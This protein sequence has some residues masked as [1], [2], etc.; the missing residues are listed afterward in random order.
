MITPAYKLRIGSK[1]IDTTDEPKASTAVDLRVELDMDTPADRLTVVF[2]QVDGLAPAPDDD[3]AVELGYSD[4]GGL[5]QVMTG[6]IVTV[7]PGSSRTRV[8]GFTGAHVLLRS[9]LEQTFENKTAG[10]IVRELC[11]QAAVTVGT[12][13]DG[14]T[15]PMYVIDGRRSFSRHI[16]DLAELC[17][18]DAYFNADGELVFQR[19]TGGKQVHVF[20]HK[21]HVIE[22]TVRRAPRRAG[23]VTSFGESPA[24][25]KGNDAAAWLIKDFSSQKG[26]AG[27]GQPVLLLE[28]P[29]LR[30]RAAAQT[31]ADAADRRNRQ[32]T[33]E[34]RVVTIGRPQ[35]RLGD[36]ITFRSLPDASLN[37]SFQVRSVVHA[38]TKSE[39]FTTTVG[40]RA[41]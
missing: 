4:N 28:R 19:F 18:C 23:S 20:E 32:R 7:E 16:H 17:G 40:F 13:D 22:L 31:A 38:M 29:A 39:G 2:G 9:V 24:G 6:T 34:G 33:L 30:T 12:V 26:T 21:K 36:A 5:S 41:I 35:V 3:F 15:F 11:K 37:T 1:L 27:S 14:I 25:T 10:A 8:I